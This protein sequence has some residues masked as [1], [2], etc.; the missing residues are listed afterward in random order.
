LKN[1][2][3]KDHKEIWKNLL[4]LTFN[5]SVG[6][7]LIGSK[8]IQEKWETLFNTNIEIEY[9]TSYLGRNIEKSEAH[10][11][12][13]SHYLPNLELKKA[14][15]QLNVNEKLVFENQTIA[16]KGNENESKAIAFTQ[17]VTL[18]QNPWDLFLKNDVAIRTDYEMFYRE[19][20]SKH[21]NSSNSIIGSQVFIGDDVKMDCVI[22]NS[23][24]GPI[25]IEDGAEIMEGSVIRGPF[26]LGKNATLKLSTK[27]YGATSIGEG[28]KVGGE[29]SNCIIHPFSNKAHDGF[30]GNAIIGS[31]CNLGA[32][33]NASN[34]K[35]NYSTI[36][37]YNYSK[38]DYI[39]SN[40]QFCGLIMGD[41]S[42]TGINTMLNTATVVGICS[43]IFGAG[44]PS[45]HIPPFSWSSVTEIE[46]YQFEKAIETIK[47]VMKRRSIELTDKEYQILKYLSELDS[48]QNL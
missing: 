47:M 3:L 15:E 6:S 33:T 41:Y 17:N 44:F 28:C 31:W 26:F 38:N 42:K 16:Y 20:V 1:I 29:V 24:S 30:I 37:V 39:E 34:L 43:N 23:N 36:K 11:V 19:N 9:S 25:I 14:I 8:S 46:N 5:K 2:I 48:Y 22:L 21:I 13:Y 4:P 18:I 10:L 7:L 35:N 27:I 40:Q 12:I 32:D 45:K